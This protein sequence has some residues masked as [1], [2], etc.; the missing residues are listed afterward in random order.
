MVWYKHILN[1]E[2]LSIMLILVEV[3][4]VKQDM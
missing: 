4:V 2:Y 3:A 1:G